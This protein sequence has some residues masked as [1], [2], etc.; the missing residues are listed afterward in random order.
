MILRQTK[1]TGPGKLLPLTTVF[2]TRPHGNQAVG[3]NGPVL[4]DATSPVA[5]LVL[6][7]RVPPPV[8][9]A[10]VG[11]PREV[12]AGAAGLERQEEERH[13]A[14]LEAVDHL[15]AAWRGHAAEEERRRHDPPGELGR[16]QVR[17]PGTNAHPV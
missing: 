7:R 17:T 16:A 9:V 15:V 11:G 12:E 1:A 14:G 3:L 5:G 6:H 2:G 8:D 13:L 10:D 4:A